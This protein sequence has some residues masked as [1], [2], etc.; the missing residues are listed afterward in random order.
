MTNGI[1]GMS[2]ID[3]SFTESGKTLELVASR[4]IVDLIDAMIS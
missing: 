3:A 1:G 2:C 4:T